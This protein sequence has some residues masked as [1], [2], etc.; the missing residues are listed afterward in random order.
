VTVKT[1]LIVLVAAPLSGCVIFSSHTSEPTKPTAK[2]AAAAPATQHA[3]A[4]LATP[5][6]SPVPAAP[7]AVEPVVPADEAISARFAP[8]PP[9]TAAHLQEIEP[10]VLELARR[11]EQGDKAYFVPKMGQPGEFMVES[12]MEKIRASDLVNTYRTHLIGDRLN[13]HDKTH[14]QVELAQ[15]DGK[16]EVS[17]LWFCR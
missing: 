13:Y 10:A 3:N 6:P 7:Q 12:M 5:A 11:A 9:P 1:L 2:S 17:R 15:K 4:A 8:L 14:V 16:W